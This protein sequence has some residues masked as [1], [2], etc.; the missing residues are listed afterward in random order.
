MRDHGEMVEAFFD[1]E[2]DDA[3]AVEDEVGACGG[4]VAD[5]G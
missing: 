5:H 2:A 4:F 1:E 3:V